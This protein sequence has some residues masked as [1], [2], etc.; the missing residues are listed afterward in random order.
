MGQCWFETFPGATS[1]MR[2]FTF[3]LASSCCLLHCNG[4][5]SPFE[6]TLAVIRATSTT[7]E[8]AVP[9]TT[10]ATDAVE[11]EEEQEVKDYDTEI[12][13]R[14]RQDVDFSHEGGS[15][16]ESLDDDGDIQGSYSY[17]DANGE[18]VE[19]KYT[20]GKDG[21]RIL[22]ENKPELPRAT[23]SSKK[24]SNADWIQSI[25]ARTTRR[26]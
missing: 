23:S 12:A 14:L 1:T 2:G 4:Q 8:R 25:K 7:T 17:T 15:R 22:N 5:L 20:A 26:P 18:L 21:F 10:D 24:K 3:L 13:L 16:K 11:V 19:V 9:V 6:E